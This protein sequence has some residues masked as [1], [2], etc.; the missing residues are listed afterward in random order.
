MTTRAATLA[1]IVLENVSYTFP[2]ESEPTLS[3]LNLTIEDGTAHALLGSSGAGKT[4]ML[5]LLS[6]LLQP[7]E[8]RILF[9]GK[10]VTGTNAGARDVA[11]VFQFPVLYESM[12]VTD[13]LI[14]PLLNRG[15]A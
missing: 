14:F 10:D 1:E 4:T 9:D 8:G 11:L 2:G 5:N 15:C 13:N 3:H 7:T 6:G 12:T